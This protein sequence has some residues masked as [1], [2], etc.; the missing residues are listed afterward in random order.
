MPGYNCPIRERMLY[1]SCKGPF[2]G[3]LEHTLDLQL[4]KKVSTVLLFDWIFLDVHQH[5]H[6]LILIFIDIHR[7]L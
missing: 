4:E 3:Q 6:Y 2:I 7:I 5:G 1:S